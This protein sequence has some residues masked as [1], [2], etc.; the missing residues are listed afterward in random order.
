MVKRID[1][2]QV[3]RNLFRDYMQDGL[4]EML[5]GA[6]FFFLGLLL[7]RGGGLVAWV[8][9]LIVFSPLLLQRLKK[10][11]T[12]P[13][14]GYVELRPGDPGPIPWFTLGSFVLG[15]VALVVVLVA[16]GVIADPAQWYRWMPVLFGIW[17]AGMFLGL[18][19]Q[20]RLVRFYLVA[21]VAL[22]AGPLAT[23]PAM[24]EKL[25]NVGLCFAAVG[26]ALLACGVFAFVRFLRRNPLPAGENADA[27]D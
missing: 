13:R 17:F 12:Y 9:L 1:L 24:G 16:A 5:L 14:T 15:L 19:L 22:A 27:S 8:V 25:A 4:M 11:F 2:E 18:G 10:R 6:F 20:V 21:G 26:G 7:P 3:E 23:L